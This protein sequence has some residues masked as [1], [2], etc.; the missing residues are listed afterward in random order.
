M[1]GLFYPAFDA[2]LV[3]NHKKK[4]M[5]LYQPIGDPYQNDIT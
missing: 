2:T 5:Y 1:H 4:I 3:C